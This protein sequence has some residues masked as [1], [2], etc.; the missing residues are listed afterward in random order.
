M[1][2][3][4][5]GLRFVVAIILKHADVAGL[6]TFCIF[7]RCKGPPELLGLFRAG[8]GASQTYYLVR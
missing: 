2:T 5:A 8:S 3:I 6:Q 7:E 1:T 4:E